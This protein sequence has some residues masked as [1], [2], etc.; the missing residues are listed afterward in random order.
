MSIIIRKPSVQEEQEMRQCP[1]WSCEVSEFEWDFEE[2]EVC[3]ILEGQAIVTY[4]GKNYAFGEGD[5]VI[6]PKGMTCH[7]R[8]TSP[9]KKHYKHNK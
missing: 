2:E 7:W 1:T 6:F 5:Y 8:V 3:L 4:E 9:I